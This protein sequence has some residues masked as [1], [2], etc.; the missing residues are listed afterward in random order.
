M[1]DAFVVLS[2]GSYTSVQDLGRFGY[3]HLGVPVS[4]ALDPMAHRIANWLVGN[5]ETCATLEMTV[6]GPSLQVLE[7]VDIALTGAAMA[8]TINGRPQ[9]RWTSVRVQSND[10]I[11]IDFAE[12]GCRA[13]LAVNGG[14]AV[15]QIMGSRS[16]FV[17]ARLGGFEGR[18]L[19]EGDRLQ[20][21]AAPLLTQPRRLP[22]IPLYSKEIVVRALPGPYAEYYR[23]GLGLFFLAEF[24]VSA[25]TNRM[26]CRLDGPLVARDEQAPN[27]ILSEPVMAGNV[28]I[29][30]GGH[31]IILMHEQTIGGYAAIATVISSDLFKIAQATP[32]DTVRFVQVSIEDAHRIYAEWNGYLDAIKRLLA[33]PS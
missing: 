18:L 1:K 8:L 27:S 9:P 25:Q 3:Q 31:P 29:P 5:C 19:R 2:P 26:G 24:T 22:W 11:R 12:S 20:R 15:P 4:G 13:Y 21:G 32:G 6:G 30:A 23:T 28:Q 33:E 10:I 17:S 16:T 7:P 14:I